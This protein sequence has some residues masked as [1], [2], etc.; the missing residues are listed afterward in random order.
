MTPG[1]DVVA[2]W[3]CAARAGER[4]ALGQA[5]ESC[6]RYLLLVARGEIDT[7]LQSKASASDLV[8]ETFLDAQRDFAQF[9]GSTEP[10]LLAWLRQILLHR[11][12]KFSRHY[13]DTA[14]RQV[15][16]EVQLHAGSSSEIPPF[17][18]TSAPTCRGRYA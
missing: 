3:L 13:R 15:G 17:E 10:E 12:N 4:E 9:Q 14:K 16:R 8:Q 1:Q 6:R 2:Q 7:A 18:V 5:L 11:I